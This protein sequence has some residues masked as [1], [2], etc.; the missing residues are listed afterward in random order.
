MYKFPIFFRGNAIQGAV[1][2]LNVYE[3]N[4]CNWILFKLSQLQCKIQ[5][6][7]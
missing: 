4:S 7:K 5:I 1:S 3:L 2:S 6:A